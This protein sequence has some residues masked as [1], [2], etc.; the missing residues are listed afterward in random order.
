MTRRYVVVEV[1]GKYAIYDTLQDTV[2]EMEI[3][4]QGAAEQRIM[5]IGQEYYD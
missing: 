3:H 4:S 5:D 1:G 2:V